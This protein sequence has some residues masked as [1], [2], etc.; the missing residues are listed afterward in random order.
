M[1][2]GTT[3][4]FVTDGIEAALENA[5]EAAEGRDISLGGGANAAQQYLARA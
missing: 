3:F 5:T 2:G 4:Y 1:E